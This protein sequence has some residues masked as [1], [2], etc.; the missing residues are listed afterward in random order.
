MRRP[1][2]FGIHGDELAV[3]DRGPGFEPDEPRSDGGKAGGQVVT[4][5]AQEAHLCA[6]L[7]ELQVP[8]VELDL[9]RPYRATRQ[10]GPERWLAWRDEVREVGHSS[11]MCGYGR[12]GEQRASGRGQGELEN[13]VNGNMVTIDSAVR[14]EEARHL[15]PLFPDPQAGSHRPLLPG[16]PQSRR[17]L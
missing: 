3:Q 9:M 6:G 14:C 12:T 1:N 11:A 2:D 5:A 8:A 17:R 13:A 16:V 10:G 7:V 15:Q 4:V